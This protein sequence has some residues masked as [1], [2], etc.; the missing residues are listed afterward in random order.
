MTEKTFCI[1]YIN[2]LFDNWSKNFDLDED[3]VRKAK[4]IKVLFGGISKDNPL[5]ANSGFSG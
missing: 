3:P 5:K 4:N 1:F 2:N